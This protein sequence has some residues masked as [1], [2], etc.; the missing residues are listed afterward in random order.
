MISSPAFARNSYRAVA[1]ILVLATLFF[2]HQTV[3]AI[4]HYWQW[5]ITKDQWRIYEGYFQAGNAISA[6]LDSQNGHRPV[7]PGFIFWLDINYFGANNRLLMVFGLGFLA[8]GVLLI[9]RVMK[10]ELGGLSPQ[11]FLALGLVVLLLFSLHSANHLAI[12][13]NTA[14][15]YPLVFFFLSGCLL[16]FDAS[17][18]AGHAA[19]TAP[20]IWRLGSILVLGL[21][22]SF[23]FSPGFSFWP[24]II[25]VMLLFRPAHW[26]APL[27]VIA[28]GVLAYVLY[29]GTGG[30][31]GAGAVTLD[32]RRNFNGMLSLLAMFPHTLMPGPIQEAIGEKGLRL[33]FAVFFVLM[34]AVLSLLMLF[35]SFKHG[36]F[37]R[38]TALAL[39]LI[40]LGY[41]TAAL[42]GMG[43]IEHFEEVT[44]WPRYAI[45]SY[46]AW[47]GLFILILHAPESRRRWILPMLLALLLVALLPGQQKNRGYLY[48]SLKQIQLAAMTLVI[49]RPDHQFVAPRLFKSERIVQRLNRRYREK[50]LNFYRWAEPGFLEEGASD[51]AAPGQCK[52]AN[53]EAERYFSQDRPAQI[54]TLR[55]RQPEFATPGHDGLIVS[56]SSGKV[57]G[58]ARRMPP[59]PRRQPQVVYTVA[60]QGHA[61]VDELIFHSAATG[62][63]HCF[64]EKRPAPK[65]PVRDR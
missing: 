29:T 59:S 31:E 28:A 34:H 23:T 38:L 33:P 11:F 13:N 45:W 5:I 35:L 48:A 26:I 10:T 40:L 3:D 17:R 58:L 54:L 32:P 6:I 56:D 22:A 27:A 60:V 37:S 18:T 64:S 50:S 61:P 14:K 16:A 39:A 63:S 4:W 25:I 1:G 2:L 49:D 43:R 53:I 24:A 9:A 19:L 7:V 55:L 52:A 36:R 12:P 44:F 42:I 20:V 65:N 15:T 46:L 41:G 47:L 62:S 21:A 57:I 8:A 30:H 51:V